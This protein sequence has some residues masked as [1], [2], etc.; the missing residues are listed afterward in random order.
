MLTQ[1][2]DIKDNTIDDCLIDE[3][4]RQEFIL[5]IEEMREF[6]GGLRGCADWGL[7]VVLLHNRVRAELLLDINIA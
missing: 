5:V 3:D 4:L 7:G 2:I 1:L 6:F